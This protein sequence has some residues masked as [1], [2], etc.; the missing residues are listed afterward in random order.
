MDRAELAELERIVNSEIKTRFPAGAVDHVMVQQPDEGTLLVRVFISGTDLATW[1]TEHRGAM[2]R[3]RWELSLRL[4]PARFLE[5]TFDDEDAPTIEMTDDG[6]IA[7]RQLSPREAVSS[8]L[9]LLR[10]N[11][12]FPDRAEQAAIAIEARLAA[13]EYDDLD[14]PALAERFTQDLHEVL[15]DKHLRMRAHPAERRRP[16]APAPPQ[17]PGPPRQKSAL[18]NFGIHRVERLA[19]NV[20]YLDLRRIAMPANAG[21]AIAAAM[22]LVR[23]TQALIIDLRRNGGGAVEG[24]VLWCSYLLPDRTHLNDIFRAST[25]ETRQFWTLPYVPGER[26]LDP[27]VYVLTSEKTFSGGEDLG[28]TLQAQQRAT[29]IGQTTGGGAHPTMGIPLSASIDIAIPNARSVSPVTGTN[30]EGTGITPD[31]AVPSEE[32]F[33]VAYRKALEHILTTD[34]PPPVLDEAREALADGGL[35]NQ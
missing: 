11:Y 5:F 7:D 2:E 16:S 9:L 33:D 10:E 15:P 14:D 19:G 29:I 24:V 35:A 4:P 13:G 30:W 8:A 34:A 20:G 21:A 23:G 12:V 22:E 25:G 6:T 27:P 1:E 32:A 26:Y 3:I 28:Y 17:R 18:D 31:V